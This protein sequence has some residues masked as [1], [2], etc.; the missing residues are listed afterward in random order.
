MFTIDTGELTMHLE[1]VLVE[2]LKAHEETLPRVAES[3]SLEFKDWARLQNPIIIEQNNIVLDGNHRTFVFKRLGFRYIPV[4]KID[5]FSEHVGLRYWFRLLK[6]VHCLDG[7]HRIIREMGGTLELITDRPSL[8]ARLEADPLIM[9]VEHGE[10]RG[11]LR[12]PVELVFDGITAYEALDHLQKLMVR[13]GA[14]LEYVP[15][16]AVAEGTCSQGPPENTLGIWTPHIT[17]DM[18]VE[19]AN[20][21]KV[22]SPKA[23][24]H[25]VGTR[26]VNVNVPIRWFRENISS[27]EMNRR[28]ADFLHNKDLRRFGPGQVINGRYYGE[29]IFVFY[30]RKGDKSHLP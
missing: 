24:R 14:H 9:G 26:P 3:L 1:V 30:D 21:G 4:C 28:F 15:C 19:A 12:F 7:F 6:N 2:S 10:S 16:Q 25:L 11:V 18:V 13:D 5:Y 29:E 22:F 23:T 8:A 17:K 27:E 20:R